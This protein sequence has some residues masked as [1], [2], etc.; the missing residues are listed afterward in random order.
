MLGVGE[1]FYPESA[2][3]LNRNTAAQPYRPLTRTF[4]L[5]SKTPYL[6]SMGPAQKWVPHTAS[7][8]VGPALCSRPYVKYPVYCVMPAATN[9]LAP[10]TAREAAP[11]PHL[12]LS[13]SSSM[14]L[15]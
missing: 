8:H 2:Q 11:P 6:P 9:L 4:P 1:W 15:S 13:P 3:G 14:L 7:S 5:S 10:T 12:R